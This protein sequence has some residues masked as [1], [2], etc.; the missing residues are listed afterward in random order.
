MEEEGNSSASRTPVLLD[1]RV[2][3]MTLR[4]GQRLTDYS[5]Q[6][7]NFLGEDTKSQTR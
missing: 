4:P 7:L 6:F 5:V 3:M 2:Y 1:S